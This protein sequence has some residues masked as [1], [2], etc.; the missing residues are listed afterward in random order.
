MSQRWHAA[1]GFALVGVELAVDEPGQPDPDAL[2]KALVADGWTGDRI[3]ARARARLQA[4]MPWPHPV[5]EALRRGC[6]AAQLLAALGATRA[7][8]GIATLV[9]RSPSVRTR[10]TPDEVRLVREVPPHHGS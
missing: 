9:T 2:A 8:L 3:A 6:G 1:I 10:L 4:G 7:A 5:P